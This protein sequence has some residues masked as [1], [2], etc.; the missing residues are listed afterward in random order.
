MNY[1]IQL[2]IILCGLLAQG[3]ACMH[4]VVG[5]NPTVST[6]LC[7]T[8]SNFLFLRTKY[9]VES[10]CEIERDHINHTVGLLAQ[11]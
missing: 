3:I 11:G 5:S 10:N 2:G 8:L 1:G 7:P 6:E 9:V 4:E